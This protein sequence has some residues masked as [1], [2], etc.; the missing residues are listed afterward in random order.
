MVTEKN[1]KNA[2]KTKISVVIPASN[3]EEGIG[4]TIRSIPKSGLENVE[5]EVQILLVDNGSTDGTGEVAKKA[6]VTA[7]L[8]PR[9]GHVIAYKTGFPNA[10]GEIIAPADGDS[11]YPIE[12]IPRLVKLLEQ[13]EIDFITTNPFG[14]MDKN[15]TS[16]QNRFGNGVLNLTARLPFRIDLNDSQSGMWVFR[17]SILDKLLLRSDGMLFSEGLELEACCFAR[18]RC[19]ELPIQYK[20]RL[21]KIKFRVWRDGFRNL[22]YLIRKRIVR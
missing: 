14:R 18:C 8:E 22:F 16:L 3:E 2:N 1:R 21:G 20:T 9:R 13:E 4:K 7:V 5:Y 6:G 19:K 12:D 17:R 15:A 11:S 10:A